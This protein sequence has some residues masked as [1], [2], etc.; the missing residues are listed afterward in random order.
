M[1]DRPIGYRERAMDWGLSAFL[2]QQSIHPITTKHVGIWKIF[3]FQINIFLDDRIGS[4]NPCLKENYLDELDHV[5]EM[6]ASREKFYAV[7]GNLVLTYTGLK[8]S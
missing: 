3:L 8:L 1:D 4:P 5:E 6:L 7:G 2:F